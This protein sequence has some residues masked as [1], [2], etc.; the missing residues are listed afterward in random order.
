MHNACMIHAFVPC[1]H[2]FINKKHEKH[3]H[4]TCTDFIQELVQETYAYDSC[5]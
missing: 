1:M 3:M 5:M 4:E 2:K